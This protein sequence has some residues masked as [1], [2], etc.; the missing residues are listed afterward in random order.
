MGIT[1]KTVV[2]IPKKI[3]SRLAPT[4]NPPVTI[5]KNTLILLLNV[6]AHLISQNRKP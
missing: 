1:Q 2:T 3:S 4:A 5:L 6:L